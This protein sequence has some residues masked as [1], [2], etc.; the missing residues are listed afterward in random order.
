MADSLPLLQAKDG[1]SVDEA[2]HELV[3]EMAIKEDRP[4]RFLL[5]VQFLSK[6]DYYV[7]LSR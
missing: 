4:S 2:L 1:P 5:V 3:V 7:L 6:L